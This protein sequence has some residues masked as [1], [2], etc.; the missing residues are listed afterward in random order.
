MQD[1]YM[2]CNPFVGK[3]KKSISK[4]HQLKFVPSIPMCYWRSKPKIFYDLV[5]V[6]KASITLY[7]ACILA[8]VKLIFFLTLVPLNP[9]IPYFCK[10]CRS[11]SVLIWIC[12]VCHS[13]CVFVSTSWIKLSDWLK[14]RSGCCI[15]IYSAWQGLIFPI[16]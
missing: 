13:V 4:C 1:K 7:A 5:S 8:G 9:D 10:Q 3:N 16:K 2:K 14:I 12:T 11:R 15:L 6:F